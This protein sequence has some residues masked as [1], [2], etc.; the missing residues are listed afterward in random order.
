MRQ[1]TEILQKV[2]AYR[3][4]EDLTPLR[5][6]YQLCE[7]R[8]K[9]QKR[10]SGEPYVSHPLEVVNILADLRLDPVCLM[11]GMLHDVVEDTPTSV[12]GLRTAFGAEVAHIVE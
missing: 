5:N 10:L 9:G 1:F 6:A 7:E 3:P 8:H 12:D 11:A 2:E 4:G